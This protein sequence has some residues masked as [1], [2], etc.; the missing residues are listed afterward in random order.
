M[1]T[2]QN[3]CEDILKVR[4]KSRA[5]W[6]WNPLLISFDRYLDV[7]LISKMNDSKMSNACVHNLLEVPDEI[8]GAWK[9]H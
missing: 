7:L 4:H 3:E 5:C 8:I 9:I 2:E 1:A 6:T